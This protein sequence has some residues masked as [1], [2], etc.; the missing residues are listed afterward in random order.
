MLI[1]ACLLQTGSKSMN[2]QVN[3]KDNLLKGL[4]QIIKEQA[5]LIDQLKADVALLKEE[6]HLLKNP[7]NSNT[8][9]VP[10]SKDD[11]R[12]TKSLR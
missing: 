9:S 1:L 12:K 5:K 10:P 7:K 11:N 4:Y 8:G 6:V 3:K 2:E